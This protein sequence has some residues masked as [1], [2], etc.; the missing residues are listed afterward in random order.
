MPI[1]LFKDGFMRKRD[2]LALGNAIKEGLLSHPM[3]KGATF[4]VDGG[5]LLQGVRWLR[6]TAIIDEISQYI[7]YI[8]NQ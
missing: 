1:S 5:A 2:K 4:V 7:S 6:N 8:G 3:P